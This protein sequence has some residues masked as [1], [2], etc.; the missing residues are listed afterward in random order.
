MR[1]IVLLITCM[2]ITGCSLNTETTNTLKKVQGNH[3]EDTS[4]KKETT[5]TV[6]K[7]NKEE[8]PIEE[9]VITALLLGTDERGEEVSRADTIIYVKYNRTDSKLMMLSIPRDS[10]VDIPGKYKDKINHA[11]AFGGKDLIKETVEELLGT[12]IDYYAKINF[13][14]F[15]QMV[16]ALDGVKVQVDKPITWHG[17]YIPEGEQV[18]NGKQLLGYV[19]FRSD[20]NGDFGRIERQ[21]EVILSIGKEFVTPNN[22]WNLPSIVKVLKQN[23]ETDMEWNK[24]IDL[25][26]DIKD[27]DKLTIE[28]HTLKTYSKK[29]NAIWYEI[30]DDENL[31]NI[32]EEVSVE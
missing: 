22:I 16:E 1:Y 26:M 11:Y 28:Q 18:L 14:G 7:E 19:R 25:G 29:M 8:I 5:N 2:I 9:E 24:V 21:R 23:V 12:K 6:N 32:K 15:T 10:Y 13:D 4:P 27:F 20:E 31:K 30:V 3:I 17:E